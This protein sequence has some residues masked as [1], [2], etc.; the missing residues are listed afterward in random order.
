MSDIPDGT[1]PRDIR[2]RVGQFPRL[3]Q[4]FQDLVIARSSLASIIL[5][6]GSS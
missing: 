3:A 2:D 6:A 4:L 1:H 5:E